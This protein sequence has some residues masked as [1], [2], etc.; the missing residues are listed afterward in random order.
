MSEALENLRIDGSSQLAL[1]ASLARMRQL[2]SHQE[3]LE[4]ASGLM[5]IQSEAFKGRAASGC[6]AED[7][8][9]LHHQCLDGLTFGEIL[10]QAADLTTELE[11]TLRAIEKK[12]LSRYDDLSVSERV[13]FT[14]S[15]LVFSILN[16]GLVSYYYNSYADHLLHCM[17]SLEALGAADALHLVKEM[18]ALFGTSVPRDQETRNAVIDSWDSNPRTAKLLKKIEAR[19]E[20][21]AR[22]LDK[23]VDAYVR[24]E[25]SQG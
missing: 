12:G 20:K 24:R 4:L 1:E 23:A 17:E 2:L 11:R 10:K 6:T 8:L 16:G 25:F 3:R 13:Y 15:P 9:A 18:N 22:L 5:K 7:L 19:E 21:I 14:A